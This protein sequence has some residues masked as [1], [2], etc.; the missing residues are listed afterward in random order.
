MANMY[1]NFGLFI[2]GEWR[3]AHSGRTIDVI[4]P[5]TEERLGAIPHAGAEDLDAALKATSGAAK[6]WGE[7]AG[8][9]T[10]AHS[11][12]DCRWAARPCRG[13][14]SDDDARKWQAPRRGARR[15]RRGDRSI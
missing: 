10:H 7:H 1:E 3:Q 5:A 11:A 8:L 2:D 4:D 13:S 14:R 12:R 9:G 15:V 6:S